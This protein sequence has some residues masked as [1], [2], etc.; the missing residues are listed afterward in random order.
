MTLEVKR[1]SEDAIHPLKQVPQKS[2]QNPSKIF[3]D[4]FIKVCK[5]IA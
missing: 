2:M 3:V 5:V 4:N 1:H